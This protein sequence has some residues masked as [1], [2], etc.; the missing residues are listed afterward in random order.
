VHRCPGERARTL[1][2]D[3]LEEVDITASL[4]E[5]WVGDHV[6]W[7]GPTNRQMV[8]P[9]SCGPRQSLGLRVLQVLSLRARTLGGQ[10]LVLD[11][12]EDKL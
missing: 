8:K 3:S 1:T 2:L 6:S 4:E 9:A 10:I 5:I 12:D 11:T 7:R